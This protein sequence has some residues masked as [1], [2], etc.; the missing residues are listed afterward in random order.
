MK[1]YRVHFDKQGKS[2]G[3][4]FTTNRPAA[5]AATRGLPKGTTGTIEVLEISL[6]KQG[7][8]EALRKY[9]SHP[10]NR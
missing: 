3:Y 2:K 6:T 1:I 4:D 9:A 5:H 8:L 7:V 10:N